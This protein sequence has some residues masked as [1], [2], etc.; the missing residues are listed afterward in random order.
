MK[1]LQ[2]GE[3][4]YGTSQ[5]YVFTENINKLNHLKSVYI[6]KNVNNSKER[7][8]NRNEIFYT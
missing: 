2:Y 1:Y 8:G 4:E 3:I 5:Y 6:H 7:Y